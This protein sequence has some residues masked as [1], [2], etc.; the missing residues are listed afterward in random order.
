M[1]TGARHGFLNR[2][3]VITGVMRTG[4][5]WRFAILPPA[6]M[7]LDMRVENGA[8]ANEKYLSWITTRGQLRVTRAGWLRGVAGKALSDYLA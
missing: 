3:G 8:P 5:P 2:A 4:A 6:A 1:N 7:K